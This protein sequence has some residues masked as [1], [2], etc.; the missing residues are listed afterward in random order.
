MKLPTPNKGLTSKSLKNDQ[1]QT[2]KICSTP[3]PHTDVGNFYIHV[4]YDLLHLQN[5]FVF[6]VIECSRY[7]IWICNVSLFIKAQIVKYE[8][9][10][11]F[12]SQFYHPKLTF[13][14][15]SYPHHPITSNE[16]T[17]MA[18]VYHPKLS[19]DM[20]LKSVLDG[21]TETLI[22]CISISILIIP[23]NNVPD[24][25]HSL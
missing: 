13:Y 24:Y 10:T 6:C 20:I 3:L 15:T 16:N 5:Y 21:K 8:Q 7:F 18:C 17:A 14:L 19:E 4:S 23:I 9:Y 2:S 1:K 11:V 22:P 25:K 12:K